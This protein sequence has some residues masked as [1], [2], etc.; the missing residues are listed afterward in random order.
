ME[1]TRHESKL[2]EHALQI[3]RRANCDGEMCASARF[4]GFVSCRV[5]AQ[6]VGFVVVQGQSTTCWVCGRAGS[7]HVSTENV[8][9]VS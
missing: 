9:T 2:R 4:A 5:S 8:L 3:V 7:V 1:A 6:F